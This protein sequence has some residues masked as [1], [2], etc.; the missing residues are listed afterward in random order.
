M[1]KVKCTE[2]LHNSEITSF[3]S[4]SVNFKCYMTGVFDAFCDDF[5]VFLYTLAS[6]KERCCVH[7]HCL[8]DR[9]PVLV[10]SICWCSVVVQVLQCVFLESLSRVSCP[11]RTPGPRTRGA[12]ST[13]NSS[14]TAATIVNNVNTL[15]T[16]LAA[17]SVDCMFTSFSFTIFV[18]HYETIWSLFQLFLSMHNIFCFFVYNMTKN[19]IKGNSH[20]AIK[21]Y[22]KCFTLRLLGKTFTSCKPI[23]NI[24]DFGPKLDIFFPLIPNS[25]DVV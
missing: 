16:N 1:L 22:L 25:M 12:A 9:L 23:G 7:L 13:C 8:Y 4:F 14:V 24:F 15:R 19:M 5:L 21:V 17:V 2:K 10:C 3:F 20:S 6:G 18:L 11:I